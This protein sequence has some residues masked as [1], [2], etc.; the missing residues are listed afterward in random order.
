MRIAL[1]YLLAAALAPATARAGAL[2]EL[3]RQAGGSDCD[4]PRGY[5]HPAG[6]IVDGSCLQDKRFTAAQLRAALDEAAL[7]FSP[8]IPVSNGG[9]LSDYNPSWARELTAF[10][11]ANPVRITCPSYDPASRP[12]ADQSKAEGSGGEIRILNAGPC[13]DDV[14]TGLAGLIFHETLHADGADSLP[15]EKHNQAGELPQY[16]F[17]TD[18]VYGTE[19]LCFYGVN[20]ARRKEVNIL[21][22]RTAV[23]YQNERPDRALCSGFGT[24]FYDTI[25]IGL[26]K[27]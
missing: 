1:V 10:L 24:Q 4:R 26:L 18:R 8:D 17:V 15:L 6:W 9:C 13:L 21:Q 23:N 25:P 20:P 12:C 16:V 7:K 22:C 3:C 27:H 2:S 19:A 14:G 11:H 5:V